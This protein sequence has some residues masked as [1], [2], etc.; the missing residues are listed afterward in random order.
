MVKVAEPVRQARVTANA[1]MN[2]PTAL[3]MKNCF[4]FKFKM[5]AINA[6]VY[7]PMRLYMN[8]NQ[9]EVLQ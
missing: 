6:P 2:T 5:F 8:L 4:L 3:A 1:A 9:E 7:E